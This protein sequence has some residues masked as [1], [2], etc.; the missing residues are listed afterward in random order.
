MQLCFLKMTVFFDVALCNLV[1][2]DYRSEVL[3][4]SIIIAMMLESV[5]TSETSVSSYQIT[6]R[7]VTE[8]I[9]ILD[10]VRT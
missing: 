7:N 6:R 1:E 5:C 3:A 4:A 10:V 9:F 2:I 8:D